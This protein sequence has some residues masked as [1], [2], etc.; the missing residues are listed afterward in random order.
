MEDDAHIAHEKV[1][2]RKRINGLSNFDL[3]VKLDLDL[4]LQLLLYTY[5]NGFFMFVFCFFVF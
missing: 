2:K 3:I 5:T 4:L 1:R